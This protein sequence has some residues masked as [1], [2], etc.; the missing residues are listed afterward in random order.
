MVI[1]VDANMHTIVSSIEGVENDRTL[2]RSDYS[3]IVVVLHCVINRALQRM[4]TVGKQ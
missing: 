1:E 4:G 3:R 2:L